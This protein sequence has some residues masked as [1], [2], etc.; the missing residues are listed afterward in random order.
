MTV[1]CHSL[2]CFLSTPLE[3]H[4]IK[5]TGLFQTRQSGG[6]DRLNPAASNFSS[7]EY[8]RRFPSSLMNSYSGSVVAGGSGMPDGSA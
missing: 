1:Q 3:I 8:L 7:V 5:T 4:G 6:R 2:S